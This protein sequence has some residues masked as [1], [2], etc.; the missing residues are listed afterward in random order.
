MIR[1]KNLTIS[2]GAEKI[3]DDLSFEVTNGELVTITG[4]SGKGKSTL[5]KTLQ[6]YVIPEKGEVAVKG[7]SLKEETID[8]IRKEIIWIPQNI[9][10]PVE[11]GAEMIELLGLNTKEEEIGK[12]LAALN[13]P[14]EILSKN[15]LNISG[16]E[17]QRVIIAVCLA[18]EGELLLMDEPTSALDETSIENLIKLVKSLKGKTILAVS[19]NLQWIAKSDEVIEL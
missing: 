19:H 16:G 6:G 11:N 5:L 14:K 18:L 17:K 15:F 4:A 8:A 9:N 12:N 13:L 3:I 7:L 1:I 10:L 2:F